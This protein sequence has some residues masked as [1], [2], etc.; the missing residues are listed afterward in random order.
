[1][2]SV[3]ILTGINYFIN[4]DNFSVFPHISAVILKITA[5]FEIDIA[6]DEIFTIE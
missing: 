4:S 5:D 3:L 1:M 2:L 6:F